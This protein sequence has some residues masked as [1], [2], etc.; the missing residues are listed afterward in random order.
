MQGFNL[1]GGGIYKEQYVLRGKI[2]KE[3]AKKRK[4]VV[5]MATSYQ[6]RDLRCVK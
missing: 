4:F 2:I 5:Y 6:L 1:Q 3:L